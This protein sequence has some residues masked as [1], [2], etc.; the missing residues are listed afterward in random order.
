[1]CETIVGCMGS[2]RRLSTL[3]TWLFLVLHL[4]SC[5]VSSVMSG[6]QKFM[7]VKLVNSVLE[8]LFICSVMS[9]IL[10]KCY[11]QVIVVTMSQV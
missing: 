2:F 1:V 5:V 11:A 3:D 8:S 6:D 7:N 9:Y 10:N 4:A